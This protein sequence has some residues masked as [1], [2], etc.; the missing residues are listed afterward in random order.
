MTIYDA[1]PH[2][3]GHRLAG[4]AAFCCTGCRLTSWPL[5]NQALKLAQNWL[6][7]TQCH[8]RGVRERSKQASKGRP[9]H[10]MMEVKSLQVS[11]RRAPRTRPPRLTTF[12]VLAI[13]GCATKLQSRRN[14]AAIVLP[15]HMGTSK[16]RIQLWTEHSAGSGQCEELF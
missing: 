14:D 4:Q 13:L 2:L 7:H 3:V 16:Q 5:L 15:W 9:V 1:Q 6:P 12:H 8:Q 11:E 10:S